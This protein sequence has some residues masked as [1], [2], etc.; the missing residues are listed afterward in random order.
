[1]SA[2]NFDTPSRQSAKG[3]IVILGVSAYKFIRATIILVIAGSIQT[4]KN[5]ESFIYKT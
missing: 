2:H 3:I 5:R 4:F 1:M